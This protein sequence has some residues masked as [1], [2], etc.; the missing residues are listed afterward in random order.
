MRRPEA[1]P[2]R[3][4]AAALPVTNRHPSHPRAVPLP[5]VPQIMGGGTGTAPGVL[6][7]S[8]KPHSSAKMK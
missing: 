7:P 5:D 1:D 3:D 8:V 4:P 6:H 2:P